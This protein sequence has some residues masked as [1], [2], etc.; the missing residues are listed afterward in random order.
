MAKHATQVQS[1]TDTKANTQA[2]LL[3]RYLLQ[4]GVDYIFGVPGGQ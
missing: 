2:D 3:I 4:V 1:G